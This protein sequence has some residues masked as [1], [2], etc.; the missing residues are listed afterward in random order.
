MGLALTGSTSQKM[1][2]QSLVQSS[3]TLGP[4]LGQHGQGTWPRQHHLLLRQPLQQV[5]PLVQLQQIT[6]CRNA[7]HL[8]NGL[9]AEQ[10]ITRMWHERHVS[11]NYTP[12]QLGE[13]LQARSFSASGEVNPLLKSPKKTGVLLVDEERNLVE[14]DDPTWVPRSVLSVLDGLQA[15]RWAYILTQM[16]EEDE[17]HGFIDQMIQ[18]ARSK[19][20]RMTQFVSYWHAA[21]WRVAMDMRGGMTFGKATQ[22]VCDDLAFYHDLISKESNENKIPKKNP[23]KSDVPDK[24]NARP[25]KGGKAGKGS[26]QGDRYQPYSKTRW[27]DSPGWRPQ[28]W[29]QRGYQNQH[30]SRDGQQAWS[31]QG[32]S[33]NK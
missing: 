21:M 20:D 8:G 7:S 32:G 26:T 25:S 3:C 15:A 23:L 27:S 5:L 1:R 33:W 17:V 14:S 4:W 30:W 19:Q 2:S 6:R 24:F 31:W 28:Q 16:G 9:G 10:V 22:A 11:K 12:L 13:L 29:N 18:R